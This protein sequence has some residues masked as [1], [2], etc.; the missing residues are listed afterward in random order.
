MK[1][2]GCGAEVPEGKNFCPNCGASMKSAEAPKKG[3]VCENCGADV[4]AGSKFCPNCG[5]VAKEKNCPK[6]G[7]VI[8]DETFC[9]NCG[10]DLRAKSNLGVAKDNF[11]EGAAEVVSGVH[12]FLRDRK[13]DLD[14][15]AET[16]R[17]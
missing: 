12:N 10:F 5:A 9:Q 4:P 8:G 6:C 16:R 15:Y 7:E 14:D 11:S 17:R 2:D 1:C 13:K 3:R